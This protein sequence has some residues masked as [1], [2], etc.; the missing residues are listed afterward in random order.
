M[1]G[2]PPN[3]ETAAVNPRA[4]IARSQEVYRRRC[5][6]HEPLPACERLGQKQVQFFGMKFF[7]RLQCAA[8]RARLRVTNSNLARATLSLSILTDSAIPAVLSIR[9]PSARA[10]AITDTRV[11]PPARSVVDTHPDAAYHCR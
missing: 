1:G 5:R 10:L 9:E 3:T 6:A 2:V 7:E 4:G 11:R 8:S